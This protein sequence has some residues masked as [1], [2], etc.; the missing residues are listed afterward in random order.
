MHQEIANPHH[1][2]KSHIAQETT[3]SEKINQTMQEFS[4]IEICPIKKKSVSGHLMILMILKLFIYFVNNFILTKGI[5]M[6]EQ[7]G[8]LL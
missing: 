8:G 7:Q 2:P 5:T 6:S 1:T 3:A 4:K